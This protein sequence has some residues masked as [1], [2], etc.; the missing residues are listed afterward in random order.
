MSLNELGGEALAPYSPELKVLI[1]GIE[2]LAHGF[3]QEASPYMQKRYAQYALSRL[4]FKERYRAYDRAADEGRAILL[5]EVYGFVDDSV[6]LFGF[7]EDEDVTT[8]AQGKNLQNASTVLCCCGLPA[9]QGN[10]E[11]YLRSQRSGGQLTPDSYR[12]LVQPE[13]RISCVYLVSPLYVQSLYRFEALARKRCTRELPPITFD[14]GCA[15]IDKE[16]LSTGYYL[17]RSLIDFLEP[18]R[19][20]A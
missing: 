2:M 13:N 7:D 15:C 12:L 18:V 1:S 3:W 8:A 17:H 14:G 6:G 20:S 9:G 4:E 19:G 16:V 11:V 5:E 10:L